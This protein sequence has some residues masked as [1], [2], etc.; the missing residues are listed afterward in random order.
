MRKQFLVTSLVAASFVAGLVA[1]DNDKLTQVNVNPNQPEQV[2]S[3]QLF[4]NATLSAMGNLR[5]SSF[6]HGL[7]S[8]WVQHYAE[9]Q[10]A[11]ADV[12]NPRGSTVEGL[13]NTLYSGALQD[14]TQILTQSASSPS[15]VGPTLT[16]RAFLV[17]E[18]TDLWG[19]MPFTE[20]SKGSANLTPK[21]DTQQVIYDSLF[22]SLTQA[23]S[24][25]TGAGDVLLA[26]DPVYGQTTGI[27]ATAQAAK[28][29]KLANSLH[30]RAALR[31]SN[32]NA[33]P[34]KG[35]AELTKALSDLTKVFQSNAD[36]AYIAWPGGT[37]TNPL[38]G[39]WVGCAG[40][41]DD[42][43]ISQRF[44]DTL[45]VTGDPRLAKYAAP[46][47]A[48][49]AAGATPCD[50]TYRGFPNGISEA[51]KATLPKN[52]CTGKTMGL[53]D[54]SRPTLTIR[55]Q[56]SPSFIMTYSELLFIRA[57]AAQRNLV[58]GDAKS[59]YE[60][61]ITASMQQ[62]G[63]TAPEIAAYL[64]KPSVV[65]NP[66]IGMKQI[67]YEKWVSLFNLENEAYAEWRRLD[68][69]VLK[70]GP[71]AVTNTVPTRLP[72]PAIENSLNSENLAAASTAQGSVD[73]TGKVWW[74]KPL[75]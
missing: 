21:Y 48:S 26:A 10:Y 74:D 42:Q 16:M 61:A 22:A 49:Q 17:E 68:Y 73:I 60:Q 15:I 14:Y 63:V 40:T 47:A 72:Y 11:E 31:I 35:K 71:N 57:E 1:C 12:N 46:T 58:P 67:A 56:T 9:I 25:T 54:F 32:P 75:P 66:A 18:M 8:L 6:E 53:A 13:W 30:A 51:G 5:G 50:S 59:L 4:T 28:W 29:V 64:A 55:G 62:W 38:C 41:R 7:G 43:R 24:I 3:Q 44:V 52:T 20:A 65:Y 2:Q 23:A 27:T 39:N 36:N 70:P 37:I 19:D 69:P 34:T 33:D 45:K